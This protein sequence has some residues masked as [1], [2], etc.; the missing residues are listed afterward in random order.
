M[1]PVGHCQQI[2]GCSPATA[3]CG[4]GRRIRFV[5]SRLHTPRRSLVGDKVLHT[6]AAPQ[7]RGRDVRSGQPR[8]DSIP[9]R[10]TRK[11]FGERRRR[12]VR[13]E[14]M[15]SASA[16]SSDR[17]RSRPRT[18]R[19]STETDRL[20]PGIGRQARDTRALPLR[21]SVSSASAFGPWGTLAVSYDLAVLD[22][23]HTRGL[24]A[25]LTQRGALQRDPRERSSNGDHERCRAQLGIVLGRHVDRLGPPPQMLRRPA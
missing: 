24:S 2:R 17:R 14:R 6:I 22:P 13:G 4:G 21:V 9:K 20:P 19:A 11:S 16:A 3:S 1:C 8:A 10:M 23:S 5:L 12:D 7:F 18:C 25:G 15:D